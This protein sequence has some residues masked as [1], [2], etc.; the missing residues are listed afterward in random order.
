MVLQPVLQQLSDSGGADHHLVARVIWETVEALASSVLSRRCPVNNTGIGRFGA[1]MRYLQEWSRQCALVPADQ[2]EM[3][4]QE[5]AFNKYDRIMNVVSSLSHW[6]TV[7]LSH[8]LIVSLCCL[9]ESFLCV[10][11][12]PLCR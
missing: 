9:C 2:M 8:W 11:Y 3:I 4:I 6:L 1:D 10:I 7:P 12:V 5:G